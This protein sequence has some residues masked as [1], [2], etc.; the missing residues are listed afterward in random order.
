[1]V[2]VIRVEVGVQ[3]RGAHGAALNGKCQPECQKA[4][5]HEAILS[6]NS[7]GAV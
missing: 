4:A 6:Q 7:I 1:M 2:V 5:E 3:E